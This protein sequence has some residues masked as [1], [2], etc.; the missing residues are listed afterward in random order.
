MLPQSIRVFS[1]PFIITLPASDSAEAVEF[2]VSAFEAWISEIKLLPDAWYC[3]VEC[4]L[5]LFDSGLF[6]TFDKLRAIQRR[7][8]LDINVGYLARAAQV[9]FQNESRDYLSSCDVK[10]VLADFQ[11]SPDLIIFRNHESVREKLRY[12]LGVIAVDEHIRGTNAV[13]ATVQAPELRDVTGLIV[14][15]AVALVEPDPS[16]PLEQ[17]TELRI[18]VPIVQ[19]PAGVGAAFSV[20][21]AFILG[22]RAV[23]RV[24]ASYA[25]TR[26]GGEVF[27]FRVFDT[28]V[29]SARDLGLLGNDGCLSKVVRVCVDVV[30]GDIKKQANSYSLRP[31]REHSDPNASQRKRAHDGAV[32][33]RL[34][35]TS[36]G[37]GIRAH[38]WRGGDENGN[39]FVEFANL[40]GKTD[41]ELIPETD[42]RA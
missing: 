12:A 27:G 16:V 19:S 28:F 22:A 30:L 42:S 1:D 17:A 37:V 36:K 13:F 6:P 2:W 3:F 7:R 20:R 32:A 26:T 21:A 41:P 40:L 34:T 11:E 39:V 33:W 15:G 14:A 18:V 35:V 4:T 29:D 23:E 38:Y 10:A 24:I 9:F 8:N 31:L 5:A 25:K